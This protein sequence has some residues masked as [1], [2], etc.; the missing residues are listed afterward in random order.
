MFINS[1]SLLKTGL[2]AYNQKGTQMK[3]GSFLNYI[4]L[5]DLIPK[6]SN[7]FS[8]VNLKE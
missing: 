2:H 7:D 3:I 6:R 4:L 8:I 5:G 1:I